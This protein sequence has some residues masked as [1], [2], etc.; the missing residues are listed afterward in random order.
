[1]LQPQVILPTAAGS[2]LVFEGFLNS[3]ISTEGSVDEFRTLLAENKLSTRIILPKP[4]KRVEVRL[5][6]I[7]RR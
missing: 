4:G 1:M 5:E 3:L 6:K 7:V 2:D